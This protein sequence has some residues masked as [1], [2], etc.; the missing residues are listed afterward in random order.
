MT[1]GGYVYMLA[2]K[3]NGTLYLGVTSDLSRR[4]D[5][6]RAKVVPSFTQKYN[7][8]TLVWYKRHDRVELA[9]ARE[10]QIKKWEREWKLRLIEAQNPEWEDL[11]DDYL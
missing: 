5:Q 4:M 6:H 1:K 3:R 9:I 11:V 7:V 10:K 8:G 2:S